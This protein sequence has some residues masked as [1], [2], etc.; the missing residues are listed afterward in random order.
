[1]KHAK[2]RIG[3]LPAALAFVALSACGGPK[4]TGDLGASQA[5][6]ELVE[7]Q[8][9]RLVDVYSYQRIDLNDGDRRRRFN[10]QLELVARNVVINANIEG[11]GLFDASGNE[12]PSASYEFRPFNKSI[13]HEELVILWDNR[14]GPEKVRF[15]NAIAGAQQGLTV[16]P[17][18]FRG[19]NT[20]SRPIPIVPRNAAVQLVFSGNTNVTEAFFFANPAAVQLLEFK[21]DPAV[22]PPADAFRILPYRIIPNGNKIIL[23]TTILG[24][25]AQ[26]GFTVPGLPASSDSVTA[27]IRV[28]IPSRGSVVS[29]FYVKE[30]PLQEQNGVDSAG[31][32]SVIR[33]FRS[34]NLNDG[35]SGRLNEP[36]APMIVASL[37]MGITNVDTVNNIVSINKRNHFVPVRA[38]Y[39]F[40]DGPL[41][42]SGIPQGPLTVP[43]AQPLRS[44]DFLTQTI[45]VEMPDGSFEPVEVRAEV[46]QN[47]Q[48]GAVLGD[49]NL[50]RLGLTENGQGGSDQ[51]ELIGDIDVKLASVFAGT[52]SLGRKHAFRANSDLLGQDCIVRALYYEDV[53]FSGGSLSVSDR[54]WRYNFVRIDPN[55]TPPGA[56]GLPVTGIDPNATVAIEFTKPMD[57]DQV[58]PSDNLLITNTWVATEPFAAQTTDPKTMT[59]R[60]VPTRLS[61]L[62]GDGTVLRLQPQLG[63]AHL[64]PT[65]PATTSEEHYALHVR[66]G[67]TGVTDLAG[68]PVRIFDRQSAPADSFSVDFQIA[69]SAAF[70]KIGYKVFCFNAEDED[71]TLPGSPDIFG[72]YRLINGRLVGAAGVRFNRTA[73]NQNLGTISRI[74]RGECWLPQQPPVPPSPNPIPAVQLFPTNPVDGAGNPHPGQ[75][76]WQPKMFDTIGPPNVPIVYEFSTT[77]SQ[78]VGRVIEPHK[79]QGSRMQMRYIE[80]DFSLSNTQ[81]SEFCLDVEQLYWAPF[82]EET[83]YYDVFDRYTMSLAHSNKRPDE[84]WSIRDVGNGPE[85]ILS[86]PSMNSGLTPLFA[87][88]VLPGT[89]LVPVFADRVYTINPN[90]V[91]RSSAQISYVPFP[92]FDRSYTWR[93]SRLVSVDAAGNVIGLGGA[94]H[95]GDGTLAT[96]DWTANMDSPWITSVADPDFVT[97]GG[98]QWVL[99]NGDFHG[100]FERDHDPIALPLLVDFKVFAD[101]AANGIASGLNSF[102]V[103]LVGPPS[104]GFPGVP[105]GYYNRQGAGC[106][107][108][109]PWPL[110]RVQASGGFDLV[111][112]AEILI[113]PA[114][115]LSAQ[116]SSVKDAGLGN[117]ARALFTAPAGDGMLNWAR[118]DFARKISTMTFGFFDTLAPQRAQIVDFAQS[119][120]AA[121]DGFPSFLGNTSQ[122]PQDMVVQMD[123]PLARQPA[124]TS[125]TVELRGA[126]SF[127]RDNILYNP[128]FNLFGQVPSDTLDV[129]ATE[130]ARGNLLSANY[131]CEAYRYSTSNQT[132][133]E[134]RVTAGGLTPYVTDDKVIQL[135]NEATGL[136]PRYINMRLVMTNNIDVSPA[137]SPGLRSVS[138]VYRISQ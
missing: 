87:E 69:A 17:P 71:G 130:G 43:I 13:G 133:G 40:V 118:A 49:P 127:G 80:D 128:N 29:T 102:Q 94:Q 86:C 116:P 52:D 63:F 101:S 54:D 39:P 20:Q 22:V 47:L 24:G 106:P 135:R 90:A 2:I 112:N 36:E 122:R 131:A 51:G 92:R 37:S 70:N 42:Q 45:Q 48:V 73:D 109:A 57:L 1:M 111:S 74:R 132:S 79:P 95:P 120:V 5:R 100:D 7:V 103:A 119:T 110:V 30:D 19:Q 56:P 97:N 91:V 15:D 124:G 60:L 82:N 72:Q 123:P 41:N 88:N 121:N 125:I 27:N 32:S 129:N 113:D 138:I 77:V 114:N 76:Y 117:M 4:R 11:Q 50:P 99:D 38:R 108:T 67:T 83:I 16:L 81:P 53:P 26:G 59:R 23:D 8:I 89:S 64:P 58:D 3:L 25:E 96:D 98:S 66:L 34:G 65:P 10:R 78:N 55:G 115:Q 105:G 136:L 18:S 107:G 134:P 14:D 33:D 126:E 31:R 12:V 85:C 9:G 35:V 104:F 62:T 61:D 75:L 44:G 84:H 46:L 93:D 137:L 28:A 6:P 68:Q 21:G